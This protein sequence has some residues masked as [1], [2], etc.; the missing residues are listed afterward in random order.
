MA[1]NDMMALQTPSWQSCNT[2]LLREMAGFTAERLMAPDVG[3]RVRGR[4]RRVFA[5]PN[6]SLIR[7]GSQV[8]IPGKI[9]QRV[10]PSIMRKTNGVVDL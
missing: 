6:Q 7:P 1:A 4:A 2:D 3:D 8:M 10:R 5:G 9:M